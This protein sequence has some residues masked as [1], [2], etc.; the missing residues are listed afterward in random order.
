MKAIYINVLSY[1]YIICE[2]ICIYIGRK[3]LMGRKFQCFRADIQK[4]ARPTARNIQTQIWEILI[5]KEDIR[6]EISK[7]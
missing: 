1:V 3:F 4:G 7:K 2:G 5:K 6:Y